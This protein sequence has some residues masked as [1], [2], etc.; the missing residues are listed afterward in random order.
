LSEIK[1]FTQIQTNVSL[2]T[3]VPSN[4]LNQGDIRPETISPY[5]LHGLHVLHRVAALKIITHE[6]QLSPFLLLFFA[7]KFRWSGEFCSHSSIN[8]YVYIHMQYEGCDIIE[9][10]NLYANSLNEPE[11][12]YLFIY[13]LLIIN[14]YDTVQCS[15]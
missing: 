1:H 9:D 8:I 6:F 11:V 2:S 7:A 15:R 4:S 3:F 13:W 5:S 10:T 12:Y 14:V